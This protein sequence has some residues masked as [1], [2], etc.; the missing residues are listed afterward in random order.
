[1]TGK[2]RLLPRGFHLSL[3]H[4]FAGASCFFTRSHVF[5]CTFRCLSNFSAFSCGSPALSCFHVASMCFRFFTCLMYSCDFHVLIQVFHLCLSYCMISCSYLQVST[6]IGLQNRPPQVRFDLPEMQVL[7][8]ESRTCGNI[9]SQANPSGK[10]AVHMYI[11][12]YL[13]I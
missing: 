6:W 5:S 3:F 10:L 7:K 11:Y 12:I 2:F 8:G 13:S 4:V 1:M 9:F